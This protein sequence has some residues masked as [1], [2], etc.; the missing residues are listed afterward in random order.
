MV[1]LLCRGQRPTQETTAHEGEI[2]AGGVAEPGQLLPVQKLHGGNEGEEVEDEPL[3]AHHGEGRHPKTGK[4]LPLRQDVTLL[5]EVTGVVHALGHDVARQQ[6]IVQPTVLPGMIR[7]E[8]SLDV[9]ASNHGSQSV[10]ARPQ[11]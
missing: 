3:A 6:Q 1:H 4:D 11:L 9:A 10:G 7:Q 5:P 8:V 2:G